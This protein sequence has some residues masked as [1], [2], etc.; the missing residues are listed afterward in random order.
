MSCSWFANLHFCLVHGNLY[1]KWNF[2]HK[3]NQMTLARQDFL[4]RKYPTRHTQKLME[5]YKK[6]DP[7]K[8]KISLFN[9]VLLW[10]TC[11]SSSFMVLKPDLISEKLW[12]HP[13]FRTSAFSSSWKFV[14]W[15]HG[16]IARIV[17][18][19]KFLDCDFTLGFILLQMW[20]PNWLNWT[21]LW[22]NTKLKRLNAKCSLPAKL[23]KSTVWR[24]MVP[25]PR[26]STRSSGKIILKAS[27]WVLLCTFRMEL[28]TFLYNTK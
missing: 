10:I 17:A 18:S 4:L 27:W 6:I 13:L 2:H 9:L 12:R 15:S 19:L 20:L 16:R 24:R 14:W 22:R 23:P 8:K 3:I 11:K 21:L 7:S 26:L 25:W 5:Q 28:S 1:K